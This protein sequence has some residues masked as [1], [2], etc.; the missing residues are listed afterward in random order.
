M[1]PVLLPALCLLLGL[2]AASAFDLTIPIADDKVTAIE[3]M[4]RVVHLLTVAETKVRF[5]QLHAKHGRS[6][7]PPRQNKIDHFVVLY[8]ENRG[9]D[10]TFGCM[11]LKDSAGGPP[12][13]G[14]DPVEGRYIP[15]DPKVAV[16]KKN[17]STFVRAQCGT[18]PYVCQ[19]G[20]GYD[21]YAGK[22]GPGGNPNAYP[23]GP[24]DDKNSY[25]HGAKGESLKLFA[26]A[27]LPIK[28]AIS[29]HFGVFNKLYTAVPTSSTPNHHF[30]QSGTS[31]GSIN[32]NDYQQCGGT[33]LLFPQLTMYDS[34]H[35]DNVSFKFY[36]NSTCGS[37]IG[38]K[39]CHSLGPTQDTSPVLS[40]DTSLAG[41]VRYTDRFQSHAAF[42]EDAAAGNL[43]SF[44]WL[45]AKS[46][47][48]DHPCHDIAKGE[49][50]QKDIY[51]ALRAGP[52][53]NRTL[54]L[55]A[56]DDA[57]GT[58][59]HVVPPHEGVPDDESPCQAPCQSFDFRRL[60]LRSTAMLISPWVAAGRVFQEPQAPFDPHAGSGRSPYNT[61]QFELTSVAG[62]VKHLFNLTTFLTKRDMWA[63]NFEEL[64]L[65]KPRTDAPMH[66]P[67]APALTG[68]GQVPWAPPPAAL[69]PSPG[70][71]PN[72]S[73]FARFFNGSN[74]SNCSFLS[75]ASNGVSS[76]CSNATFFYPNGT[77]RNSTDASAALLAFLASEKAANNA[78]YSLFDP[79]PWDQPFVAQH[80]PHV[81]NSIA[82][83]DRK[84]ESLCPG[85]KTANV[86]QRREI[87]LYSKLASTPQPDVDSMTYDEAAMHHAWLWHHWLEMGAPAK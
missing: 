14:V 75:G 30:T 59:D 81:A 22:F 37:Q 25:S 43:S 1:A 70:T 21:P 46:E 36:M 28:D 57:G 38:G 55:I 58:Y 35:L 79:S 66:L 87:A 83:K 62:T 84:P 2:A 12:A 86:K 40:P 31:C 32:N 54:F 27:Q 53:W 77:L 52:K 4:K 3:D 11:G 20:P 33:T 74:G 78:T 10:H 65:D 5:A 49:R 68:P 63:G 34:M 8:Q 61:S 7:P 50:Q 67:D 47:A 51:E 42:Y 44:S 85:L 73:L 15:T 13:D 76:N 48:C 17:A 26:K 56:Y 24:M 41:V 64:L 72:M 9:F 82:A 45:N 71:P 19:G 18:A 80:C 60:G 39:P 29:Q 23:Y 16:D 6:T 69:P